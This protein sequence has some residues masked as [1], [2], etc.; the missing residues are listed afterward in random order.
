M[1]PKLPLLAPTVSQE[2]ENNIRTDAL[3]EAARSYNAEQW[4]GCQALAL[5]TNS[6]TTLC[7]SLALFS[8]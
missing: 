1:T 3:V 8:R 2:K 5:A 7:G 4:G 6:L